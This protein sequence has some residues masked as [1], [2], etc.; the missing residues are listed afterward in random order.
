MLRWI[1]SLGLDTRDKREKEAC[2]LET[3]SRCTAVQQVESELME[4]HERTQ[5]KFVSSLVAQSP[6]CM[7]VCPH[8]DCS[9]W[10]VS[11]SV[12]SPCTCLK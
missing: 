9:V 11:S 4:K 12:S 7:F 5:T 6:A 10:A 2:S 8:F 3:E 1:S